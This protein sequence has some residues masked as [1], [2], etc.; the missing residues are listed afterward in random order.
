MRFIDL[1]NI[2]GR[3]QKLFSEIGF[4]FNEDCNKK[5]FDCCEKYIDNLVDIEWKGDWPY[6]L[7]ELSWIK[8]FMYRLKRRLRWKPHL[9]DTMYFSSPGNRF[10]QLTRSFLNQ[11]FLNVIDLQKHNTIV[12]DQALPPYNPEKYLKYF[13]SVKVI[14]VDRDPRDIFVEITKFPRFVSSAPTG[15]VESFITYF[16]SQ[17]NAVINDSNTNRVMRVKFED[18]VIDYEKELNKIYSFLKLSAKDHTSK[19]T[20]F[21]PAQSSKQVGIWRKMKDS[22]EIMLIEK[23]LKEYL[24]QN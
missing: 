17:R 7:H 12:L 10:Y 2:N 3:K 18:M 8:L 6:H 15:S 1:I 9:N 13:N 11:L 20:N 14:V 4:N 16:K 22:K 5:F 19:H 24:Y 23:E 21:D